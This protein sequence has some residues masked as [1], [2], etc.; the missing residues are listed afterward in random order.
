MVEDIPEEGVTGRPQDIG[1]HRVCP[2][3]ECCRCAGN[4]L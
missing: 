3:P 4:A 2:E 1:G